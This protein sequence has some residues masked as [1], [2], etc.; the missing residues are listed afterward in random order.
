MITISHIGKKIFLKVAQTVGSVSPI[1]LPRNTVL[2]VE[3][4]TQDGYVWCDS[5]FGKFNFKQDDLSITKT[6]LIQVYRNPTK[7]EIKFGH[8]CTIYN[9]VSVT[10]IPSL[11]PKTVIVEGKRYKVPR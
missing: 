7:E 5:I 10:V 11:R 8:G 6:Q 2:V 4:V 1:N 3:G 9:Y